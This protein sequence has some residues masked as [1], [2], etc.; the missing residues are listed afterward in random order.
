MHV[1]PAVGTSVSMRTAPLG[2]A[3]GLTAV[4]GVI[5]VIQ[6]AH[7]RSAHTSHRVSSVGVALDMKTTDVVFDQSPSAKVEQV[8]VAGGGSI[9]DRLRH[10]DGGTSV[11][12]E[13]KRLLRELDTSRAEAERLQAVITE[14][15]SR[16]GREVDGRETKDMHAI[17][18]ASPEPSDSSIPSMS[19]AKPSDVMANIE[20][21]TEVAGQAT[22]FDPED[23]VVT[24]ESCMSSLSEKSRAKRWRDIHGDSPLCVSQ[25]A[26]PPSLP[27]VNPLRARMHA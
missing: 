15:K 5:L 8:G 24:Y 25:P 19:V 23:V 20:F 26:S 17:P 4:V 1:K 27:S 11:D 12:D 13:R 6:L 22:A 9:Q 2:L 21:A 7:F 14:L 10:L 3:A 16:Q 18:S